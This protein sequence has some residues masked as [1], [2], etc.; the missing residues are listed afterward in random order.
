MRSEIHCDNTKLAETLNAKIQADNPCL[1]EEIECENKR[2]SEALRKHSREENEKLRT[3]L[4]RMLEGKVTKFQI[5]MD[6]L[7]SNTDI[8]ILSVSY[9]TESVCEKLDDRLTGHIEETYR[10]MDRITEEVKTK[11]KVLEVDLSRHVNDTDGHVQSIRQ[12]LTEVKQQIN[13]DVF[14]KISVCNS[15]IVVEKQEYETNPLKLSQEIEKLKKGLFVKLTGDKIIINNNNN[16]NG[17]AIIAL[18]KISNQEETVSVV[19]TSNQ[20]S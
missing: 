1:I 2:F 3:E 9:R 11:T 7:H 12:E 16:Y 8:E 5:A 20:A 6:K 14:D 13:T 15:Q 17:C 18:A 10:R 19:S 4:S